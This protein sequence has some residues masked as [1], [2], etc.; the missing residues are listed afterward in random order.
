MA[1]SDYLEK[2]RKVIVIDLTISDEDQLERF[3]VRVVREAVANP[4][5]DPER[6]RQE[7]LADELHGLKKS[8]KQKEVD[9]ADDE[10]VEAET[11]TAKGEEEV[12]MA[13]TVKKPSAQKV[14][15]ASLNDI[16]KTLNVMRSGRSLK[17][18]EVK[19]AIKS[20]VEQLTSGE[21]QS[22]FAF[23]SGLA[24]M[25][26]GGAS[27]K[28]ATDPAVAGVK[29][30]ATEK[31]GEEEIDVK[32]ATKTKTGEPAGGA[33]PIVVGERADRSKELRRLRELRRD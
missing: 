5:D 7:Q 8:G 1:E 4:S 12:D 2:E 30:K 28:E 18:P 21:Q 17:D 19:G 27:G 14:A 9:E 6:R 22:L 26:V 13:A 29:T 15:K 25:M 24:E 33:T 16:I 32:V 31:A 20:Y 11:T 10:E 23:L 3:L